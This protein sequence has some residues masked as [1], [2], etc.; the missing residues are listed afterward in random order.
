MGTV[1]G[2]FL[3]VALVVVIVLF[4][5]KVTDKNDHYPY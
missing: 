3:S 2:I 5:A 4:I 1:A